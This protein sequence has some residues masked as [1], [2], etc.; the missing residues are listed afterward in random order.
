MTPLHNSA[1]NANCNDDNLTKLHDTLSLSGYSHYHGTVRSAY[2]RNITNE[3]KS[4]VVK[5]L[6]GF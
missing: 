2:D 3:D 6:E 4:R 5:T 1:R